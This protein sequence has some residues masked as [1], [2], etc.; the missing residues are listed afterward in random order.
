MKRQIVLG[1]LILVLTVNAGCWNRRELN[2]IAIG[3]AMGFDK[4]GDKYRITSQVVD[5]GEVAAKEGGTGHTP[6]ITYHATADTLFEALR[7]MTTMSP[8]KIYSSHVRMVVIG[9][10]LARDGIERFLDFLTRDHE[11]RADYFF[12]VAKGTTA[13]NVLKTFTSLDK[14]PANEL[15][16]SLKTSEKAWAPTSSVTLHDLISDL[17]S[18]G[19]HPVLT[20]LKVKGS[21]KT[22]ESKENVER[23]DTPTRLQYSGLGVFKKDKLIGWLNEE[24]SKGY[25]YVMGNVRSTVGDVRCPQGGKVV[26]EII[27]SKV[28]RKGKVTNGKPEVDVDIRLEANVGEVECRNLDLTQTSTINELEEKSEQIIKEFIEK[29]I[30]K[31][32]KKYKADIFGFGE[33]IRRADPHFWRT[34]E[35]T[36]DQEFVE[37]PVNIKIDHKIRRTGTVGQSFLKA[38]EE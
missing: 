21:Q 37:L 24:E 12:V 34:V 19:K 6:V 35:K 29:T 28:D 22:G 3:V 14:I 16:D 17:V 1:M 11:L 13:E 9:E 36:W 26:M 23:I 27:R 18:K 8:R 15:F 7:K 20:G 2:E 33:A 25:N 38:L 31:A 4:S 30:K 10:E 5:P 32:Q